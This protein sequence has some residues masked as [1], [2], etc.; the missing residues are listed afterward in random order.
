MTSA[1]VKQVTKTRGLRNIKAQAVAPFLL[2][3]LALVT[4]FALQPALTNAGATAGRFPDGVPW[5]GPV[6]SA[7]GPGAR[8]GDVR[9]GELGNVMG[10]SLSSSGQ[11]AITSQPSTCMAIDGDGQTIK[12]AASKMLF[13][14]EGTPSIAYLVLTSCGVKSGKHHTVYING[15]P[16]AQVE[17]DPFSSACICIDEGQTGQG[18]HTIIYPVGDPGVV[19]NG[20]NYISVT[21]D[22]D[23]TDDWVAYN[24]KLTLDGQ[25]TQTVIG[26]FSFT[27]SYDGSARSARYQLPIDYDPAVS[28]P[29]LVSIAGTKED[30]KWEDL[31][32][33]AAEANERGWLLLSPNL[34]NL[35]D[36]VG[37]RTASLANQ[38]DIIDAIEYVKT[39][40]AVDTDRI[41]L[42]GFSTGGGVAATLAAKYP[43]V[44]AAVVDW[45]GPT[46]L[47]EWERQLSSLISLDF[48]CPPQGPY[49]CPLEWQRRSARS[50]TENLKHVPVAIVH[51]QADSAV[52]F[53]QS[54][55]FYQKMAEYY[56]PTTHN[57]LTVWHEG[58]HVDQLP[59]FDGLD[60]MAGF[61]L[62]ANPTDIMIRAD[63][64]KDYYWVSIHQRAWIGKFREGWSA[65]L[66]SYDLS[67]GVISATV[68][69]QR[70]YEN[71]FLPLDV[72]FD[73]NAMGFNPDAGYSIEDYNI[74]TGEYVLR[75]GV[76]PVDGRLTLALERD[77]AGGVHHQYRAYPF[78]APELI[79]V[80]LQQHVGPSPAYDGVRDT[81]I[82]Q[83]SPTQNYAT[84]SSLMLN[85]GRSLRGLLEF[86]LGAIPP[87]ADIK[88]VYLTLYLNAVSGGGSIRVGL[89]KLLSDWVDSEATW[90][91]AAQGLP[92]AMP[93]AQ[94]QGVDYA[95]LPVD[96]KTVYPNA[97]CSFNLKLV[98][99]DWLEDESPNEGILILGPELGSGSTRYRFDSSEAGDASR[100]PRLDILYMLPTVTPLPSVTPTPTLTPTPTSTPEGCTIQGSVTLQG[101]PP[102]PHARWSIPLTVTVNGA[103]YVVSTDQWGDFVLAGL[104]P[105]T[106]DIGVKNS[107][108]LRAL[109]GGVTLV[110][111]TN[112]IDF[113]TLLEGDATNDNYVNINDFSLLTAGFHPGY[114]PRADFNE[115]G[116]VNINDFSLLARNFGARGGTAQL[117]SD[118]Q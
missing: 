68:Q 92:W 4:W 31:Y 44:F 32:R 108:T 84:D 64:D 30:R 66:A 112:A 36:A 17:D 111:G 19:V 104:T 102:P 6:E 23:L 89:Y 61:T 3:V 26:T 47:G 13:L 73:L 93:G 1:A 58:G 46:D 12:T 42:S 5:S 14:W 76:R 90:N 15:Q 97:S 63:E 53:E 82:Y 60:W 2:A 18:G 41:Y 81:Y 65:V 8:P 94:G 37:G 20:W 79:N 114:D 101:R 10:R 27:S 115:D 45:A 51:G 107:H 48:G 69:D 100:R 21:N 85:Y 22:Q 83:Y 103:S 29:L 54:D 98:V 35:F 95:L 43:H 67:T 78:E 33:F 117:D 24:A 118:S 49:Q 96:E 72:S 50:M 52:P 34:R 25:V 99:K 74:T 91:L 59:S 11:T 39:H 70:L 7:P 62:N 77:E 113:G 9:V 88:Q 75:R 56:D 110:A 55:K 28:A 106:Y 86:D 57:K 109:M 116:T 87:Q 105:G 71:G 80:S 40:F 38:H 16:A